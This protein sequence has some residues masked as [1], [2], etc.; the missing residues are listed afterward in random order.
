MTY[1]NS[2]VEIPPEALHERAAEHFRRRHRLIEI[3]YEQSGGLTY[4]FDKGLA[5]ER[6]CLAVPESRTLDS[7]RD[8]YSF[9]GI[10][11]SG[12]SAR[13]GMEFKGRMQ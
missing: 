12:L 9:A 10:F 6:L 5:I 11:E 7:I 13:F 4:T 8:V 1:V 2:V 3:R